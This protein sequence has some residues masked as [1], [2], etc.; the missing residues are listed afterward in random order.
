MFHTEHVVEL[1]AK[2]LLQVE[3]QNDLSAPVHVSDKYENSFLKVY[4][5]CLYFTGSTWKKYLSKNWLLE[6]YFF[7]LI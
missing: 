1:V 7:F 2:L 6:R 4:Y 3:A 5:F